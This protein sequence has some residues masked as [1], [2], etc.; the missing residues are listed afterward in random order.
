MIKVLFICHGNIFP[1]NFN[2]IEPILYLKVYNARTYKD[3]NRTIVSQ[4]TGNEISTY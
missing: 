2:Y 3:F 1:M 4:N